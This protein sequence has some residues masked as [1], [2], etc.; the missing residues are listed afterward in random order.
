MACRKKLLIYTIDGPSGKVCLSPPLSQ[1]QVH[2]Q[3]R[4]DTTLT[5]TLSRGATRLLTALC[6]LCCCSPANV[7]APLRS[8]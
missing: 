8:S 1:P 4:T 5:N 2:T 7:F 6:V 3:I